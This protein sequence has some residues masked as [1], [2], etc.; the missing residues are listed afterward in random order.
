MKNY[1]KKTLPIVL[2]FLSISFYAQDY[3]SLFSSK[4]ASDGT[5]AFN[6]VP[7]S[8]ESFFRTQ[9]GNLN[10]N[11][12]KGSPNIQ[13]P[14]HEIKDGILKL[15][16]SLN[17]SKV[18]VKVNDTP[19]STGMN[20]ILDTGGI[21][22]RTIYDLTDELASQRLVLNSTDLGYLSSQAGAQDLGVYAHDISTAIDNEIDIFNYSIPGY[23]GSFYLDK[24]LKPVLLT[25][26]YNLKLEVVG[27][28]KVSN[29]FIITTYNGTKYTFGGVGATEKT[30][31]RLQGN[32][33]GITSFYL[34]TIEDISHNKIEFTYN[35]ANSKIISLGEQ[36]TGQ[37]QSSASASGTIDT[38]PSSAPIGTSGKVLNVIGSKFIDKITAGNEV[39]Q[40]NYITETNSP[41]QKIG[42]IV[43]SQN[44]INVKKIV[45]DYINGGTTSTTVGKKRF[46]LTSVKEYAVKNNTDTFVNEYALEYNGALNIP[47]RL[48]RSV[49]YLGYFN[50]KNNTALLPNLKL[51][52][53]QYALFNLNNN[54]ADRRANFSYAQ[55]GTLKSI[56][57]PTKGKTMFEYESIQ[58][59]APTIDG[60]DCVIGNTNYVNL[61]Y[62]NENDWLPLSNESSFTRYISQINGN[63]ANAT[64]TLRLHSDREINQPSKA[65]ALFEIIDVVT[66]QT[67]FSKTIQVQKMVQDVT[68]TYTVQLP[69]NKSYQFKF[70]VTDYCHECN[71]VANVRY[72]DVWQR[73]EDSNIRLKKQY[74]ISETG[75]IN[76]KR[77]YYTDY[78]NINNF[79]VLAPPFHPEFKS[80][81]YNQIQ[82]TTTLPP[83]NDCA[84]CFAT[85]YETLFHSDIQSS[86]IGSLQQDGEDIFFDLNDPV[87]RHV[88]ISYGGD[89]F[90]KGGEEKIFDM[91]AYTVLN[92]IPFRLPNISGMANSQTDNSSMLN[93]LSASAEN[94]LYKQLPLGNIQ[95]KL[96]SHR[97]FNNKNGTLF[98]KNSVKSDYT[99]TM[100][101]TIYSVTGIQ[102]YPYVTL[103]SGVNAST[104]LDNMY[105]GAYRFPTYSSFLNTSKTT[106]YLEDVPV[107]VTDDT[108]Y[109]KLITTT[110]YVYDSLDKQLSKSTTQATDGSV[111]ETTY[112]YAREKIIKS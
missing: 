10:F 108:S 9:F 55:L 76:I 40:F 109:K 80:F 16:V 4:G 107:S 52:G 18:G 60:G 31:V 71:G 48:S 97:V 25:Q 1:I 50:G 83:P 19:N 102:L 101:N 37:L 30:W 36:E 92:T 5:D 82:G 104:S 58:A 35:Q 47:E 69:N 26:D 77:L 45:F 85:V 38:A 42:N 24:T 2:S 15:P 110:N 20:W 94:R 43:I 95:G 79:D 11:E 88:T 111:Q 13:I 27:D 33:S 56:T 46:F 63:S 7:P 32:R 62:I 74:D 59:K 8:P 12:F 93:L 91:K 105:I 21:I 41:F 96:I 73:V 90:E 3:N 65:K 23:S 67:V 14:I 89:N 54:Y 112:L 78:R 61:P 17:Y 53:E 87:Y 103:P 49:D 75:A 68:N 51:F 86:K 34:K 70:R 44:G 29:S 6:I 72:P 64:I 57:Y 81:I 99:S 66:N 28:F 98:L 106:E 84:T 22:T 100:G 39:I